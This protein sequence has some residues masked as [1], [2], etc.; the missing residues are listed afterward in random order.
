MTYCVELS[1]LDKPTFA[2]KA[3]TMLEHLKSDGNDP[4]LQ[5]YVLLIQAAAKAGQIDRVSMVYE[6]FERDKIEKNQLVYLAMIRAHSIVDQKDKA[7]VFFDRMLKEK[8]APKWAEFDRIYHH[9]QN[10]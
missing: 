8:L 2:D 10:L 7:Q 3:F 1:S 6:W 5:V 4:D 9:L